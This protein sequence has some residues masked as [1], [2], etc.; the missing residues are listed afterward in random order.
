VRGGA[1]SGRPWLW[2]ALRLLLLAVLLLHVAGSGSG[3]AYP[4]SEPGSETVLTVAAAA[5]GA[6]HHHR[7]GPGAYCDAFLPLRRGRRFAAAAA[8][9]LVRGG[10]RRRS[11]PAAGPPASPA[12]PLAP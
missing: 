10:A 2:P 5:H 3:H 12:H 9:H 4:A 11:A 8:L 7:C 1:T 6:S